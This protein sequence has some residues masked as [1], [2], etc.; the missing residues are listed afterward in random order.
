MGLVEIPVE[1]VKARNGITFSYDTNAA[2][3][4][5]KE[6]LIQAE[7]KMLSDY[8]TQCRELIAENKPAQPPGPRIAAI[9]NK[10]G[11]D[12]KAKYGIVPIG[13]DVAAA[14][15]AKN[16]EMES[17][18]EQ[19]AKQAQMI[20]QLMAMQAQTQHTKK[21]KTEPEI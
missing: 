8:V 11:V 12:L 17:M 16:L 20:E 19:M 13:Y 14:G 2:L 18:R 15:A 4:K 7:E 6:R 1:T 9:I 5:A 3:K 21:P 10:Y